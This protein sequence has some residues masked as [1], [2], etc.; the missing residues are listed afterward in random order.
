LLSIATAQWQELD[1]KEAVYGLVDDLNNTGQ[2]FQFSKDLV[3]KSGLVLAD[4]PNIRFSVTNFN[5]ANMATLE[6]VWDGISRALRLAVRL[7]ADFG[8]SAKTLSADSVVIPIAYYLYRITAA[9]GYR[10]TQNYAKDREAIRL[11]VV[12]SLL[13][14]GIWGSGLD[15]LLGY[16]RAIIG[17]Y[18]AA[19][20]PVSEIESVMTQRGKSIRFGDEELEELLDVGYGDK[21]AL[22]VLSLLYPGMD[23]HNEFHIDHVFPRSRFTKKLLASA[24]VREEDIETYIDDV[25]A[26]SNLRLLEGPIN[27]EK[28]AKLPL[29]W[30]EEHY[31]DPVAQKAY[32]AGH[33]LMDLTDSVGTFGSFFSARRL[34]IRGRLEKLLDV[35]P[36]PSSL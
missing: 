17:E 5:A 13:K 22:P 14:R 4:I 6:R 20:F 2:G 26:L 24:G 1:A 9:D 28:G 19:G 25:N 15:T 30:M 33:D 11:W 10:T 3:L 21:R 27:V 32:M 35:A 18:G 34:R 7:L 16:L 12:R 29:A 23:F 8:F 31:T 36:S